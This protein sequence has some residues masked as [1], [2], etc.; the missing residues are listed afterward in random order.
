M[1]WK[2]NCFELLTL[3]LNLE[4]RQYSY[5]YFTHRNLPK[6]MLFS[7]LLNIAG[8]HLLHSYFIHSPAYAYNF[9][10]KL[11]YHVFVPCRT[12]FCL[13]SQYLFQCFNVKDEANETLNKNNKT[14]TINVLS[15]IKSQNSDFLKTSSF[16]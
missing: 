11:H 13:H 2:K 6:C 12:H 8:T 9:S 1:N 16:R 4:V 5:I 10:K 3:L 14:I 7:V 15:K